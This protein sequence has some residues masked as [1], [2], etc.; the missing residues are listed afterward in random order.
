MENESQAKEVEALQ[1]VLNAL[2]PLPPET[3]SRLL[4]SAAVFLNIDTGIRGG[5]QASSITSSK[6]ETG[7]ERQRF[8]FQGRPDMSSKQFMAEKN[9]RSDIERVACLAYYLTHYKDQPHFK[10]ADI[11]AINR[12]AAQLGFSN[13]A[14]SVSNAATKGLL[15]PAGKG[16]KQITAVGEQYVSALPDSD[17]AKKAFKAMAPKRR[18]AK[19]A[20]SSTKK[21]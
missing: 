3:Q 2:S 21:G 5:L 20:K 14:R 1:L 7:D 8:E 11:T 9:P 12:E 19:Q 13:S 15:A 16:K 17:A 4:S 6:N 18:K 10:T